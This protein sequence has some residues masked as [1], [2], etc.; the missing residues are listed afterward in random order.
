MLEWKMDLLQRKGNG[1]KAKGSFL[2]EGKALKEQTSFK[3]R[4]S[5]GLL[6]G[7]IN[8]LQFATSLLEMR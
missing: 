4:G 1:G 7:K 3:V 8:F 2:G 6:L 5:G